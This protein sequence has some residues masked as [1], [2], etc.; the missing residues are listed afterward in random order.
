MALFATPTT[1]EQALGNQANSQ[2][3]QSQDAYT[4]NRKRLIAGQAAGGQLGSGVQNYGQTDLATGEA[5]NESDIYSGLADS[6]AGIPAEDQLNQEQ[7][8]QNLQLAQLI[9]SLNKPSQLQEAL[10]TVGTVSHI[11][12]GGYVENECVIVD[13]KTGERG[14]MAESGP[15]LIIRLDTLGLTKK[16]IEDLGLKGTMA[17]FEINGVTDKQIRELVKIGLSRTENL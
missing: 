6:L 11:F 10:G 15:E 4:Q 2:V 12:C 1:L 8:N 5:N 16:D 9:G 13:Q 17:G 3:A 7:Y 14:I